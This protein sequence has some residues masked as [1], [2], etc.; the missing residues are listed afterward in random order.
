MQVE[1]C[2]KMLADKKG[3]AKHVRGLKEEKSTDVSKSISWESVNPFGLNGAS[4]FL[5][6]ASGEETQPSAAQKNLADGLDP[7]PKG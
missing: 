7:Y 6:D 4:T 5:S 1:R 2:R 3:L